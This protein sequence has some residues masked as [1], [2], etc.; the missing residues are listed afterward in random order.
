MV[1]ANFI[2]CS[3]IIYI[4]FESFRAAKNIVL[5]QPGYGR[6]PLHGGTVGELAKAIEFN[7]PLRVPVARPCDV[8]LR[9]GQVDERPADWGMLD[10]FSP[11]CPP[12]LVRWQAA[13]PGFGRCAQDESQAVQWLEDLVVQPR[14]PAAREEVRILLPASWNSLHF[15]PGSQVFLHS[16]KKIFSSGEYADF[17]FTCQL[18]SETGVTKILPSVAS[19]TSLTR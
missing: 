14:A 2:K 4:P 7:S 11:V 19:A 16:A 17:F 6:C 12:G 18:Q 3:K 8:A 5:E 13:R 10:Q 9:I 15:H 1:K